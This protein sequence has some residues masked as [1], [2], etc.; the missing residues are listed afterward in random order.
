MFTE[1]HEIL[2]D[3]LEGLNYR[4][5]HSGVCYGYA[6][7]AQ[8][9]FLSGNMQDFIE[10]EKKLYRLIDSL[11]FIFRSSEKWIHYLINNLGDE[12]SRLYSPELLAYFDTI[13]LNASPANYSELFEKN[14]PLSQNLLQ[15]APYTASRRIQDKE[16]IV[17]IGE[18][19]GFYTLDEAE[20]YFRLIQT[21][22][23]EENTKRIS[24]LLQSGTHAIQIGYDPMNQ[25]WICADINQSPVMKI[26]S[27]T[28]L[29]MYIDQ[30]LMMDD[31]PHTPHYV[32]FITKFYCTKNNSAILK[33]K[34]N[35]LKNHY[36][37]KVLHTI[38]KEKCQIKNSSGYTWLWLS[39]IHH[40]L[41]QIKAIYAFN[42]DIMVDYRGM[43]PFLMAAYFGFDDV[44][45]FF[46]EKNPSIIHFPSTNG[47][48][49]LSFAISNRHLSTVKYLLEAGA[50]VN[51][52]DHEGKSPLWYAIN[53][54]NIEI[55]QCLIQYDVD[56]N[57]KKNTQYSPLELAI[58]KGLFDIAKIL[59]DAG[60]NL[61]HILRDFEIHSLHPDIALQLLEKKFQA[62]SLILNTIAANLANYPTKNPYLNEIIHIAKN[63]GTHHVFLNMQKILSL[64]KIGLNKLHEETAPQGSDIETIKIQGFF[65]LLIALSYTQEDELENIAS[66]IHSFTERFN[67]G[68]KF[69]RVL[70]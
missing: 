40:D 43:N 8:M 49:A 24:L 52:P 11:K 6:A 35:A 38:K 18:V 13:V 14:I 17:Q 26:Q 20:K 22:L 44:L 39:V 55:I 15:T 60:A 51:I 50:D 2:C 53:T 42:P 61:N 37:F 57:P 4:G 70:S 21:L 47:V 59:V 63:D 30:A 34:V 68:I 10:R 23:S 46:C 36:I 56:V 62:E 66:K 7:T 27:T 5:I 48:S 58:R 41:E 12:H 33:P 29:V 31:T 3:V 25:E 69:E 9:A 16:G 19:C 45:D 1:Y 67:E 28:E 64:A 54:E 32:G 65:R